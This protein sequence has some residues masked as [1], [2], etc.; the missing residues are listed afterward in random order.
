MAIEFGG[1]MHIIEYNI[2]KNVCNDTADCGAIYSGRSWTNR[3]N[4]IRYNYFEDIT[5]KVEKGYSVNCVY[6]DDCSSSAEI[7]GNVFYNIDT[8]L[9]IGGGRN[10]EFYN[11]IVINALKSVY[12]D[13][14][15]ENDNYYNSLYNDLLSKPYYC[16]DIWKET[17]PYA[18]NILEDDPRLP[19]YNIIKNNC[20]F[21][22]PDTYFLGSANKY[23]YVTNVNNLIKT[24]AENY[25]NA[26]IDFDNKYFLTTNANDVIDIKGFEQIPFHNCGRK[27]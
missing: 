8:A 3:G 5:K 16:N 15:A 17:F 9:L 20:Y 21:D 24:G 22:A 6:M 7:F 26:F 18:S 23:V 4:V 13:S 12:I 10:N 11:N 1:Q 27:K 25:K 14:R 2:I 19:K